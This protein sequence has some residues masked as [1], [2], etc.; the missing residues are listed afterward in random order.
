MFASVVPVG[1][2]VTIHFDGRPIMARRGE[3]VAA[4]LMRAG[5]GAFRRT[6]ISGA[7]RLPYCMIGHCFDCL[8]E[9]EGQG[10]QQA[11][12]VCVEGG[13]RIRSHDGA[14]VIGGGI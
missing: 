3:T 13:M 14:S 9:I 7:P 8:V 1:H 12:L 6:P 11:C 5:V 2:P 4:C 10:S